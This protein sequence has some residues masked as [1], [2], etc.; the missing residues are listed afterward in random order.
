[1]RLQSYC[2]LPIYANFLHAFAF[3]L[4]QVVRLTGRVLGRGILIKVHFLYG[5][6]LR[7][8]H[9]RPAGD[10]RKTHERAAVG[11]RRGNLK[12]RTFFKV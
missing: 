11:E 3:Y 7:T 5:V 12:N 10:P 2:F 4:T 9:G 6:S 1:M 8:T